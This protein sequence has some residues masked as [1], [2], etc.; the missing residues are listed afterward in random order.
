MITHM[1]CD[2]KHVSKL[3]IRVPL[4]Q[5]QNIWYSKR[6]WAARLIL[7]IPDGSFSLYNEKTVQAAEPPGCGVETL[8]LSS[9]KHVYQ[10]LSQRLT[11][12]HFESCLPGR[13]WNLWEVCSRFGCITQIGKFFG[14]ANIVDHSTS[15]NTPYVPKVSL[16]SLWFLFGLKLHLLSSL[17]S[18]APFVDFQRYGRNLSGVALEW[19]WS[20]VRDGLTIWYDETWWDYNILYCNINDWIARQVL[21]KP[22]NTW[23]S[24][25]AL[26]A[27]FSSS[28]NLQEKA[29][30]CWNIKIK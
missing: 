12:N 25:S 13:W 15:L 28:P 23:P 19:D 30:R 8:L 3:Y 22:L 17:G 24:E 1:V 27:R 11:G 6:K 26:Q 10:K 7:R 29:G 18:A 2:E 9:E 21:W 5:P 16:V 14:E 20:F 4:S